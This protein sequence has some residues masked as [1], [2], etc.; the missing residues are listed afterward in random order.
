MKRILVIKS[1]SAALLFISIIFFTSCTSDQSWQKV[2]ETLIEKYDLPQR[3]RSDIPT[4]GITSNLKPGQVSSLQDLPEIELYAGVK[5]KMYWGRG[6][7]VSISTIEAGSEIPE[8]ILPA[9]RFLFV[10]EGDV[11]QLI[12]NEMVPMISRKREAPDGI[13][14][15]TPRVDFV[16]LKKGSS[17]SLKAGEKGA[18]IIEIYSPFRAD[19]MEKTGATEL[20]E[21][22]E[23]YDFPIPAS[24]IPGEVYDLYDLQYT[25]LVP[26]AD[27][28]IISGDNI[29]LSFLTMYPGSV[30]GRHL[31]P[32]EQLMMVFRGKI[33]EI[34]LDGETMMGPDD[35]L[36]LP[37]TM[38]HGGELQPQGCDVLDIFWPSR[39]DYYDSM[40]KRLEAYHSIIPKESKVEQV[41]DG[42][43][44][45]P[46]LY[47][48]E[49]PC[50]LNGKLYFSNMY[51]DQGW[52]GNPE[53]SSIVEMKPDGTYRNITAGKM[54]ANGLAALKNGN[55]AVCNMFG[56]KVVEM[57]TRGQIKRVL[58]EKYNG[59]LIDGPNDLVLDAKG[60][61]Y[62]TDPQF[63]PDENK[64]QPGRSVYYINPEGIVIRVIEPDE[65]AMPNGV[66]LSP[67]GKTL[68]VNNTYDDEEWW[69]VDSDKDN[70]VWAYDVNDDGT[71]TNGRAFAKLFLTED[72]L[73]RKGKTTSA[74]G[75]AIDQQGN[76]YV[77]TMAGLQIFDSKGEFV[78]IINFPTFPVSVC[79]GDKDMKTLYITSYSNI[80]RIRTN[81]TG[82]IQE[83]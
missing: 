81:M 13:H 24:V 40:Q 57:T 60:G 9:N 1:F 15:A 77:A 20:P 73:D 7:L 59:K 35:L 33:N 68:Y 58:A 36:L 44:T 48:T 23:T 4:T 37:G 52:G 80:Y 76:I 34:I 66:I 10:M 38:V 39:Q 78:G 74:D 43:K 71:L 6:A 42:S 31:H 70:Y 79:F 22:V 29:Q 61:I 46:A 49:G 30:F 27:S 12:D 41:I 47:F 62:F 14:G 5:S 2:N 53:K 82:F 54:Q 18:K 64:N 25:V 63:T 3:E 72:V 19:Y 8:E 67:D 17:S 32:E 28:R 50:W 83:M 56:H 55:L 65:F 69:N 26:G 51:F 45:K 11:E 21:T 75:M 16:Y